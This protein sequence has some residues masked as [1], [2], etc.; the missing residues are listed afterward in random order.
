[1]TQHAVNLEG[2]MPGRDWGIALCLQFEVALTGAVSQGQASPVPFICKAEKVLRTS[3]EI[4]Q[5]NRNEGLGIAG[6]WSPESA[7]GRAAYP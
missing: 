5:G 4:N 3:T 1:M 2:I 6:V 7:S